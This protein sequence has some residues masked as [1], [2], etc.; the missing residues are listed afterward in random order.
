MLDMP[1][2][3]T[4]TPSEAGPERA[5]SGPRL[6]LPKAE[7]ESGSPVRRPAKQSLDEHDEEQVG[8]D[9]ASKQSSGVAEKVSDGLS[10]W[11][12]PVSPD[13][14]EKIYRDWADHIPK[15]LVQTTA[16]KECA[17]AGD[18]A[19]KASG[20]AETQPDSLPEWLAELSPNA[21]DKKWLRA[22]G[23]VD[24]SFI[25]IMLASKLV[26]VNARNKDGKTGLHLAIQEGDPDIIRLLLGNARID[27][28]ARD[29]N[30]RTALHLAVM[31]YA[32]ESVFDLVGCNRTDVNAEDKEGWTALRWAARHGRESLVKVLLTAP[33]IA[34]NAMDAQ[35]WTALRHAAEGRHVKVIHMLLSHPGVRIDPCGKQDWSI[36]QWAFDNNHCDLVLELIQRHGVQPSLDET[37]PRHVFLL[38]AQQGNTRMVRALL[39]LP[40]LDVN[41]VA[42]EKVDPYGDFSALVLAAMEGHFDTVQALLAAP[43][44]DLNF[45]YERGG[46]ALSFAAR[47]DHLPVVLRLLAEPGILLANS[48]DEDEWDLLHWA[49]DEEYVDVLRAALATPG[50]TRMLMRGRG[51]E[52][53]TPLDDAVLNSPESTE[54][55]E[56]L[57]TAPKIENDKAG[58]R[59]ALSWAAETNH[60][61]ATERLLSFDRLR[62]D[63]D[64]VAYALAIA[65]E[66]SNMAIVHALLTAP[67]MDVHNDSDAGSALEIA[68]ADDKV[69]LARALAAHPTFNPLNAGLA[70]VIH[71]RNF[72]LLQAVLSGPGI[73]APVR[74]RA[75]WLALCEA[76]DRQ[77]Q[78]DAMEAIL[79]AGCDPNAMLDAAAFAHAADQE[80]GDHERKWADDACGLLANW[81]QQRAWT[82][83]LHCPRLH[84]TLHPARSSEVNQIVM[85]LIAGE[86]DIASLHPPAGSFATRQS[87]AACLAD[88]AALGFVLGHYRSPVDE[89]AL[90]GDA[91]RHLKQKKLWPLFV[92]AMQQFQALQDAIDRYCE[93][94]QTLLT[95]A[96]QA[97]NL[98]LVDVLIG[99]GARLN[100]PAA[101]GDYP[102]MAAVK[103]RQW[104]VA[105]KLIKL[106]ARH[107][108]ADRQARSLAFHV[109]QDF[110]QLGGPPDADRAATLIEMLLD[111]DV[112]F[113]QVNPDPQTRKRFPRLADLLV[114][115]PQ[116]LVYL[117]SFQGTA[118]PS[119][120]NP[121]RTER[122]IKAILDNTGRRGTQQTDRRL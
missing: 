44:I 15:Y 99:L 111:R 51:S 22:A 8:G 62:L 78:G 66:H 98:A 30:C 58:C 84:A 121:A 91:K 31:D 35:G 96:A 3:Q 104:D 109:C 110:T 50:A 92:P 41:M 52:E 55:I 27:V 106:G 102:L 13:T 57:L 107:E 68:V 23:G 90:D 113:D 67:D 47:C 2:R 63:E 36:L 53:L 9:Q 87:A 97:G 89:E 93:D 12:A 64:D 103:N 94:G 56:L 26:D 118:T 71:N 29:G 48:Q 7:P 75:A 120:A 60:L 69:E 19:G 38:A 83:A 117:A 85:A 37:R 74:H 10:E 39:T 45:G 112:A 54:I 70:E 43:G 21:R 32:Y 80:R 72:A 14:R 88:A 86:H 81:L 77:W 24:E 25:Q 34:V 101:D 5:T 79:D 46:T 114:S 28:N 100:M 4:R 18:D 49:V 6:S 33:S 65:A 116:S 1:E 119:G 20:E 105:I 16:A 115:N 17:G 108:L 42:S 122:L 73:A 11:L 40:N 95:R 61:A 76:F 82:P 59:H